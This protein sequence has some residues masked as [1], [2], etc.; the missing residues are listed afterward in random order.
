MNPLAPVLQQE[1]KALLNTAAQLRPDQ[2][3]AALDLLQHCSSC[4]RRLRA[5]QPHQHPADGGLA[6]RN[7]RLRQQRN[8]VAGSQPVLHEV[9]NCHVLQAGR[10]EDEQRRL[11]RVRLGLLRGHRLQ[12]A[13]TECGGL[14]GGSC[15]CE[16]DG[17]HFPSKQD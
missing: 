10:D 16:R 8:G 15:C 14:E 11:L 1:A 7:R 4:L 17:E 2:A 12:R 5:I 6:E 9:I 13:A 3:E